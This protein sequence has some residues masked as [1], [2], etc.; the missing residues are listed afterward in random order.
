MSPHTVPRSRPLH[1]LPIQRP[2][3]PSDVPQHPCTLNTPPCSPT[4]P[5]ALTCPRVT[6]PPHTPFTRSDVPPP[7]GLGGVR[8]ASQRI[9]G[10]ASVLGQWAP[11]SCR[12]AIGSESVRAILETALPSQTF[13]SFGFRL[14]LWVLPVFWCGSA[15]QFSR[16]VARG[17]DLR[18]PSVYLIRALSTSCSSQLSWALRPCDFV[19]LGRLFSLPEPYLGHEYIYLAV[20]IY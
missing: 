11:V 1:M 15:L 16:W 3:P 14:R 19:T 9:S 7:R 18:L 8:A 2:P 10:S 6:L 13:C 4:H 5:P 17:H 12:S 20:R